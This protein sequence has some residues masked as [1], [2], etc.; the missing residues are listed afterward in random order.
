MS[1]G[2]VQKA[3]GAESARAVRIGV[4]INAVGAA[5][6]LRSARRCSAWSRACCIRICRTPNL[7]LPTLLAV[8]LPPIDRR[9][10]AGRRARRRDQLGRRG[11]VHALHVVVAGPL[12]PVHRARGHRHAG[13]AGR[14]TWRP[15]WLGIAG[16]GM[17]MV[18]P[19][20][21]DALKNFYGV[22]TAALFVPVAA[23]LVTARGGQFEALAAMGV[24]P[25][26][27]GAGA[28]RVPD[29]W[30][31]GLPAPAWGIVAGASALRR[32][33]RR[34]GAADDRRVAPDAELRHARRRGRRHVR[35]EAGR[36][37]RAA[38]PQRRRQDDDAAHAG[39]AA[40][41]QQRR[42]HGRGHP[43][44]ARDHRPGAGADRVSHRGAG[45]MGSADRTSEPDGLRAPASAVATRPGP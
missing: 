8:D 44:V 30:L 14:A 18:I 41:A 9:A 12:S 21:V 4:G 23:S 13:A 35:R 19:T 40:R 29:G 43:A 3:Y 25:G 6:S 7:A 15:S 34:C 10:H 33:A 32:R 11:A 24:G 22:V 38:R 27:V 39:G 17:A 31:A 42:G 45:A 1:P 37:L 28:I 2:L 36:D 26:R 5:A 16:V 20:V